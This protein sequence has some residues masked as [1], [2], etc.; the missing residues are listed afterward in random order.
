[1]LK[2]KASSNATDQRNIT[3]LRVLEKIRARG[4]ISRID[5]ASALETSPA[6]ITSATADLLSAGLIE[7]IESETPSKSARRGRPRVQLKLNG[8]SHLIAGVKVARQQVSVILVD[9]E[10]T[11]ITSYT[12]P[13]DQAR[14]APDAFAAKIRAVLDQACASANRSLADLS[15]VC[16]GIAGLIDANQNFVHW[17]SS[18]TERN[19]DL[20]PL[21]SKVLP[22]PAFIENDA[23]LVAKAEQLFGLG[24]GLKNFLVVTIEHGI[25]LGIVLDGKL[26]RGE[27]GCGA[28]FGHLKV[29]LDGALCQCGQRGCLEAYVGEYAL[30]REATI[31]SEAT[32]PRTLVDIL[33]AAKAGDARSI[34]VLARAGQMFGMGVSNLINLFDPECIILSGAR[35]RFDYLH[36]DE[37][38][39]RVQ[40]GVVSVDAPLPEIKVNHWGDSMWAKGAAAYGIE[41]VSILKV[42]ELAA[43]AN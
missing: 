12:H 24:K 16:I 25:G 22:C 9:F 20:S 33:A 6:T 3:R 8:A 11:E 13:L 19:V 34:S 41:Q 31:A 17:S 36:S 23:N 26:Y 4:A 29:Q 7:E 28:E 2:S 32:D 37:V 18:L 35:G 40:N 39:A 27:R 21:L 10:G 15:G 5:I 38:M 43:H 1:M 42:R 30:I 14:M